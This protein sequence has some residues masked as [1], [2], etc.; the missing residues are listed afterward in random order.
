MSEGSDGGGCS[1]GGGAGGRGRG[2]GRKD[3]AALDEKVQRRLAQNREAAR[4][5]RQRKKDYMK[6][7]EVEVGGACCEEAYSAMSLKLFSVTFGMKFRCLTM[8]C[9][10]TTRAT[11]GL[12]ALS[13]RGTCR[14]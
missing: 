13:I 7:L 9:V 10:H 11:S 12:R 5:S 6:Q 2:G 1:G 3:Y 4:K 8:P 14:G